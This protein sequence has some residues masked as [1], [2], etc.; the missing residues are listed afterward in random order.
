MKKIFLVFALLF[1]IFASA[2][3]DK[4]KIQQINAQATTNGVNL[5]TELAYKQF[6]AI[7]SGEVNSFKLTNHVR[8][9]GDGDGIVIVADAVFISV[10][11][12]SNTQTLTMENQD[13]SSI[14]AGSPV[15]SFPNVNN[16][17]HDP[18]S[19]SIGVGGSY[20]LIYQTK[21]INP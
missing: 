1:S 10:L 16:V 13:I 7:N 9:L 5:N 3:T 12:T 19:F 17:V 15:V 4:Q 21:Y 18:M 14:P 8:F 2:Q 11:N 20:I 6:A